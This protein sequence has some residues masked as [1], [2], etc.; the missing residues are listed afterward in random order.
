MATQVAFQSGKII[1]T[2]QGGSAT[3]IIPNV[4]DLLSS[5]LNKFNETFILP[6]G[7]T[8][9]NVVLGNIA[10]VKC[11]IVMTDGPVLIKLNGSVTPLTV[12]KTFVDF[13]SV[14]SLRATNPSSTDSRIFQVYAASD[15]VGSG[16]ATPFTNPVPIWG[17]TPTGAKDG[18]NT[19]F[20]LSVVPDPTLVNIYL[21]GVH[22]DR[23]DPTGTP[24]A[25]EFKVVGNT[26]IMGTAPTSDDSFKADFYPLLSA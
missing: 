21:G 20:M 16:S 6:P 5:A 23:I 22:Q 1:E 17:E 4:A 18:V 24:I 26:I 10:Q 19:T 7:V 14:T 12:N 15:V 8:D 13:G 3:T 2:P 11:L 9:L 25:G